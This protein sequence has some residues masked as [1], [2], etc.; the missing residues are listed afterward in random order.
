MIVELITFILIIMAIPIAV[1]IRIKM[2]K[3]IQKIEVTPNMPI[4]INWARRQFTEGYFIGVLKSQI[5]RKNGTSL[6]EFYAIDVEQGEN[7]PRP[8]V[9]SVI[10]A[11]E[12]IKRSSKGDPSSRREIMH[13]VGRS[14]ADLPEHMRDTL[15]GEW[16]SMESQKAW[17]ESTFGTAITSGDEA[18]AEAMKGYARGN[19]A[20]DVLA[21][22]REENAQSRK[23]MAMQRQ[24]E[25]EKK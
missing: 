17:L 12:F 14:K 9:Q 23:L 4:V 7:I 8:N 15:E 16:M 1:V 5:K 21:R 20:K 2:N 10:V 19:L 6:I 11:D 3:S 24:P 22:L 13:L 18:I 25:E